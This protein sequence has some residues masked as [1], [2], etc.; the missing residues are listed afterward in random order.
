[1]NLPDISQEADVDCFELERESFARREANEVCRETAK[2]K[3]GMR[4]AIA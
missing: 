3:G 4:K 2:D 1:L